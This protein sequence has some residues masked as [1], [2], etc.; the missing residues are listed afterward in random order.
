MCN[1]VTFLLALFVLWSLQN[2]FYLEFIL[3]VRCELFIQ[4]VYKLHPSPLGDYYSFL[5]G[6]LLNAYLLCSVSKT[7]TIEHFE[8]NKVRISLILQ[9]SGYYLTSNSQSDLGPN[10]GGAN[11]YFR[12]VH[13]LALY[14]RNSHNLWVQV[15]EG[16][17][18]ARFR[19]LISNQ[20]KCMKVFFN[21]TQS[22]HRRVLPLE[23]TKSNYHQTTKKKLPIPGKKVHESS[24]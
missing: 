3:T 11:Y 15:N 17:K 8:P 4:W 20:N 16:F 10:L 7:L 18:K 1:H 5:F 21:Y 24:R 22:V 12:L 2:I 6:L 19:F 9:L 14:S 23:K 13:T